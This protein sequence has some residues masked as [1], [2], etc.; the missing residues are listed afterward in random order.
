MMPD[1]FD[2]I[3]IGGGPAGYTAALE[4]ASL[5][6]S[7]LLIER[8]QLGGTCLNRGCIPTK[9][10]LRSAGLYR[11]LR[12]EGASLGVTAGETAP[13]V[14]YDFSAMH[15]HATEV[16]NT[17]RSGIEGL[18]RRGKVEVVTGSGLV[19]DAHTVQ[20]GDRIVT[21]QH[22]LLAMGSQP[23]CPPIPGLEN[24]GVVTSDE[25]LTGEGV[26][27]RHLILIGGGVIGV[28]FA[29]IYRDLGKEVTIL[30]AM[31]RLLPTLDREFGQSLQMNLKKRGCEIFT[32]AMVQGIEAAADG[33]G[34]CCTFADK[35]GTQQVTGDCV[36]VCTGRRPCTKGAF[37]P[38]VEEALHLQRGFVPVNERYETAVPSILAVGDLILGGIQLA[39]AAE[40]Q[41]KNAVRLLFGADPAKNCTIIP[42][43]VFT[44][45]EIACAG[46][47]AD[48]AKE[49]GIDVIVRKN[50]TSANGKALI[51][52]AG[53]GF[54]K[55]V[56]HKED[57]V[58][59]GAQLL[60]P[61]AGE[62]IGTLTAC[63]NAG[64]TRTQ[65]ETTV[66]PHPTVSETMIP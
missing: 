12:E 3:V 59:V 58:L 5:S 20:V 9:A 51:E 4:A 33:G 48:E 44:Q 26:D 66:F 15:A 8:D 45:P 46:L 62:M 25:M 64:L 53:R 17:L 14:P 41:A 13:T 50:L 43:C 21:G 23:A 18:L 31:P 56:Y 16:R 30:E 55:L 32:G 63:I 57:E 49:Q 52:G 39:H 36:L 54:V 29:Q 24:P 22:I 65:M 1:L 40:A 2:L 61:H 27:C 7:V 60:C 10:L 35:K 47:T 37:A 34:L 11:E 28:E 42:S 6:R 19:Q 38:A